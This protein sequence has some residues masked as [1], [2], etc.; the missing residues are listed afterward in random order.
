MVRLRHRKGRR[1]AAIGLERGNPEALVGP[2]RDFGSAMRAAHERAIDN[3]KEAPDSFYLVYS[4][5]QD[6]AELPLSED[7]D[8][9]QA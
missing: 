2:R 5:R 3:G 9:T 1:Q 8:R 6:R 7:A 4:K